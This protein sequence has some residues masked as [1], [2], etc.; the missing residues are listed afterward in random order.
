MKFLIV[1][2][3]LFIVI[4]L[5]SKFRLKI[6]FSNTLSLHSSLNIRYHISHPYRTTGNIIVS[7]ILIFKFLE[8]SEKTSFMII[9]YKIH[10]ALMLYPRCFLT[11]RGR[12]LRGKSR[13]TT[14]F[15]HQ[16]SMNFI[17]LSHEAQRVLSIC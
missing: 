5:G 2:S 12:E 1:I 9:V 7:Y 16:D 3:A 11:F 17:K 6:V 4:I 8:R 13:E 14:R 10:Q 15:E